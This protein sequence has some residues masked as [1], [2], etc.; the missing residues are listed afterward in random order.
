MEAVALK[1][2]ELQQMSPVGA[3]IDIVKN[4]LEEHKVSNHCML[5]DVVLCIHV[6]YL[7]QE[8]S[9]SVNELKGQIS[10]V[11]TAGKQLKESCS[12]QVYV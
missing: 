5:I 1:S 10:V 9:E 2:E 6:H 8:F 12:T 11:Q 4:Q 7:I 3:D